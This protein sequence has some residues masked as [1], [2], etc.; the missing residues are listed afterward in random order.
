MNQRPATESA[1]NSAKRDVR[2][3]GGMPRVRKRIATRP[4][5]LYLRILIDR[6]ERTS[7]PLR[8][9]RQRYGAYDPTLYGTL[10]NPSGK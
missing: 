4:L 7:R 5:L 2:V 1:M 3:M 9:I 10:R 8:S 6:R